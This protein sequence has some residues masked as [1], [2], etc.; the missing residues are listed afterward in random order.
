MNRCPFLTSNEVY[1]YYCKIREKSMTN[2]YNHRDT[3]CTGVNMR[4]DGLRPYLQCPYY[5]NR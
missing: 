4:I 1:S 3:Y 2:E 5:N